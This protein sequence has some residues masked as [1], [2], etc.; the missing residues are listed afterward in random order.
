MKKNATL[1]NLINLHPSGWLDDLQRLIE[2]TAQKWPAAQA[3]ALVDCAFNEQCHATIRKYNP[4]SRSLY[5]LSDK[6]SK[7]LQAVSPTLIPLTSDIAHA[8][9]DVIALTD[10]LPM[11]SIIVTPESLDELALRLAPWCIVN[12]DGQAFVFRF[13]DTRRLP[14]II[15]VLTPEQHGAIFGPAHAWIY[16]TRDAHWAELPL[17]ESSCP[18]AENIKLDADQ[19][20]QLISESEAD[21]ILADLNLNTPA[22]MNRYLPAEA[23]ELAAFGLKRANRYGI[24]DTDRKQ[25]CR[26][27]L[28]QPKL[29]Q[30]P[31]SIPLLAGLL[32]GKVRFA[33]IESDLV[34]VAS[35]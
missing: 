13:P 11:L 32:S 1:P 7:Q 28:Q 8:C 23:H 14:G 20:A 31:S 35:E 21:E 12:A 27:I 18:P 19:Y 4:P 34:S 15:D 9:R 6:P 33:D 16:R 10:G 26:L 3:F 2:V 24:S 17:S 29:E 30:L 22:L 5:D 25:W